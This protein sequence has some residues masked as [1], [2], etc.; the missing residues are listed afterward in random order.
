MRLGHARSTAPGSQLPRTVAGYMAS[1]KRW[2]ASPSW[3][4]SKQ[5]GYLM[6]LQGKIAVVTGA[7]SG[8]GLATSKVLAAAG[9]RI[10]VFDRD[11][12]KLQALKSDLGDGCLTRVVDVADETSVKDGIA[13]AVAA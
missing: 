11:E 1:R 3:A 13:A 5:Q 9:A 6:N 10:A 12:K 2:R 7:A 8:L 4:N